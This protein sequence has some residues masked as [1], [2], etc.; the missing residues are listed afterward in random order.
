MGA[1]PVTSA[2]G[3]SGKEDAG[4]KKPMTEEEWF[5]AATEPGNLLI[6]LGAVSCHFHREIAPYARYEV[7]TRLLTW[8]RKWLY[9]VSHFV[10]ADT[11]VPGSYALQPWKHIR[12]PK[13]GKR[14]GPG[15][16]KGGRWEELN[17][18][19]RMNLKRKVFASSIA[20]YVVKKGRLTVPP[21][22]VLERS[23]MLPPRPTGREVLGGWQPS[24]SSTSPTSLSQSPTAS[25]ESLTKEG[26]EGEP[27]NMVLEESLFPASPVGENGEW[28]W[29]KV[30]EERVKGLE[31]AEAY[32]KLEG[33]KD[34]FDGGV[35]GAM[36]QYSDLVWNW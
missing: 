27:A 15:D 1:N 13:G 19:E 22:M 20:K 34:F 16:G 6:A 35:D 10:E 31:L 24:P 8:D 9:I 18:R 14:N 28:T 7:W 17:E 33:L 36:G 23:Q 21:E 26:S 29:E 3:A 30:Q 5:A 2:L 32:D 25:P 11:F 4:G 12:I